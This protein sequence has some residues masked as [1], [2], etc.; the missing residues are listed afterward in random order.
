MEPVTG[1]ADYAEAS[2]SH[3]TLSSVAEVAM[4]DGNAIRRL[5]PLSRRRHPGPWGGV[6]MRARYEPTGFRVP[7]TAGRYRWRWLVS[8][9]LSGLR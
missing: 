5:R 9:Y 7:G 4:R 1:A 3:P 8:S 6:S 2:G